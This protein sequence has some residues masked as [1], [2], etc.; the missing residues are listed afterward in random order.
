MADG[1]QSVEGKGAGDRFVSAARSPPTR[2][3]VAKERKTFGDVMSLPQRASASRYRPRRSSRL[4]EDAA[5]SDQPQEVRIDRPMSRS[6]VPPESS[7]HQD[8]ISVV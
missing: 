2:S 8:A 1:R 6:R 4:G 3:H 7:F 5:A